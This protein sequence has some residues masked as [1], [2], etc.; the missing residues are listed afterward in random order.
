[1]GATLD[2]LIQSIKDMCPGFPAIIIDDA[3]EDPET[4]SVIQKN[5]SFFAEILVNRASKLGKRH[6]NLYSNIHKSFDYAVENGF[7][8][9]LMVQDDMQFVRAFSQQVREE[10]SSLFASD[11]RV[12][13]VDPRFLRR[14]SDYEI[15]PEKRAYR[16]GARTSYADVGVTHVGRLRALNWTFRE[17]ERQNRDAL[18]DLGCQRLFPFTPI[19]THVPFPKTFRRGRRKFS[20]LPVNR[21]RY[22]YH[23]MSADEIAA[24]DQRPISVYPH[25]RTYLRPKHM[26]LSRIFYEI[27]KDT[28]VFN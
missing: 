13:Q 22:C 18:A 17:G 28:K 25:F 19:A 16:Y 9:V 11:E 27:R 21:G 24:M 14:G 15:L 4:L 5:S 6:G 1:M 12:I 10:Y 2:V 26:I 8:Y 3:S 7:D 20:L 23:Y